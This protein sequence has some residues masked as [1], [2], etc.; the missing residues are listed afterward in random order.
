[1]EFGLAFC[2]LISP[3]TLSANGA[4]R[5][6]RNLFHFGIGASVKPRGKCSPLRCTDFAGEA[7]L[8]RTDKMRAHRFLGRIRKATF[9]ANFDAWLAARKL[10]LGCPKRVLRMFHALDAARCARVHRGDIATPNPLQE[11]GRPCVEMGVRRRCNIS[12]GGSP[13]E[14]AGVSRRMAYRRRSSG[15]RPDSRCH[16]SSA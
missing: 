2:P 1:M 3:A 11:P 4:P 9:R 5:G 6:S 12:F 15:R 10:R 16:E 7:C 8:A 14:Q 13:Q